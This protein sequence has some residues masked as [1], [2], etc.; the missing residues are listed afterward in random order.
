MDSRIFTHGGTQP[1]IALGSSP[2]TDWARTII[3]L[4]Y[5]IRW[6]VFDYRSFA[7]TLYAHMCAYL[8][9][10][11]APAH[12]RS[13]TSS[14]AEEGSTH[15][16]ALTGPGDSAG[17]GPCL[18]R[19]WHAVTRCTNACPGPRPLW[20]R[21]I[22]DALVSASAS[23]ACHGSWIA[24]PVCGSG[25]GSGCGTGSG[26]RRRR[27]PCPWTS[28]GRSL[29]GFAAH[30]P[31][32]RPTRLSRRSRP[33]RPPLWR[34]QNLTAGGR[35]SSLRR[36]HISWTF[37]L[38]PGWELG[39]IL[40]GFRRKSW[41]RRPFLGAKNLMKQIKHCESTPRAVNLATTNL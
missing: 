30:P 7:P 13:C 6:K 19:R 15:P 36:G 27:R 11:K 25:F 22:S 29:L 37:V 17:C 26:R 10:S 34:R 8:Y 41:S 20:K 28:C 24:S 4:W 21:S 18:H 12:G 35:P 1:E 3:S 2:E 9:T 5:H 14:A 33:S 16:F 31:W 39:L 32:C 23:L 38:V 40:E